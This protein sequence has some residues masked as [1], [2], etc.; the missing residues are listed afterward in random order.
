M[1]SQLDMELFIAYLKARRGEMGLREAVQQ[2]GE[3]SPATLSRIENGRIPDM[4][5]F[6]RLSDWIGVPAET[7][8]KREEEPVPHR[9]TVEVIEAHLRADRNL[10]DATA[11][12]IAK[13]V[14]AAYSLG[15]R[16]S[17]KTNLS[18][19]SSLALTSR[20]VISQSGLKA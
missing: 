20:G 6:L 12:A 11:E 13:M 18:P 2:I 3:I 8:L 4:E 17:M 5:V 1:N 15:L 14:K 10:D 7:F 19:W 9:K 16:Q